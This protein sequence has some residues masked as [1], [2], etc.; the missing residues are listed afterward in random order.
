MR[1]FNATVNFYAT[2]TKQFYGEEHYA[3]VANKEED[4]VRHALAASEDSKY[5]DPRV[6]HFR[7]VVL[8]EGP[9]VDVGDSFIMPDPDPTLN[10]AW[11]HGNWE[12]TVVGFR[13]HGK[14]V[15]VRDQ[16]SNAFDIEAGRVIPLIEEAN[17]KMHLAESE[18][19]L[20][21]DTH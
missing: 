7:G 2:D 6:D 21:S 18:G 14:L 4:A 3:I 19:R 5:D 15:T 13:D 17:D 11:A 10:D 12:A 8:D 1:I 20:G 16:D 9:F